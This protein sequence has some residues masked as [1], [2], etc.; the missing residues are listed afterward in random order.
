MNTLN[1]QQGYLTMVTVVLIVVM[2][3]IAVAIAYVFSN[4]A[5]ST[6]NFQAANRALYLADSGFEQATRALFL[7]D[8]T[9]RST[10]AG[11]SITNSTVGSGTYTVTGAGPFASPAT[12]TTLNGALTSTATTITVVSTAGY[13]SVGRIMLD[14]ELINYTAV[15]ATHFLNATRGVDSSTAVAHASGTAVGQYQ[16]NLSSSGGVPTLTLP[17]PGDPGGIRQL[18]ENI[19]LQEAWTVGNAPSSNPVIARFNEATWSNF[20]NSL[21]SSALN[22]IVM[23]SYSDG[24]AVGNTQNSA[25]FITHWNGSNWTLMA[26]SG[27]PGVNLN[28]ISCTSSNNCYAVGNRNSGG[29]VILQWNGSTWT[30]ATVNNSA[31]QNLNG[32]YCDASNDCWAVGASTGGARF[33]QWNGSTWNG[34]TNSLSAYPFFGVFCNTSTDCWAVGSTNTFARKNGATWSDFTT[35]LPNVNYRGVYCNTPSDCWVVADNSSGAVYGHWDGSS[36][37]RFGP[38]ASVPNTPLYSIMCAN[39]NDCWAVGNALSGEVI[40]HWDGS[41]WS[42]IGPSASIPNTNLNGVYVISPNTQPWSNWVESF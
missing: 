21:P 5:F 20:S 27:I 34:V 18:T 14:R 31:N 23:L 25:A 7:P 36:W 9:N 12:P 3:F 39:T 37:T 11:L 4:N 22:S 17:N 29:P 19:Q 42:L 30:Q 40:T 24:W 33:Y 32:V 16:C 15:D 6:S 28:G 2:S 1:N 38:Y 8:I 10:C 41:A 26:L 35:S 13:Q